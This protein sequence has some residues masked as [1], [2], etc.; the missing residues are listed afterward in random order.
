MATNISDA[1]LFTEVVRE[2]QSRTSSTDRRR[3]E[4]HAY[5]TV[6]LA[7]PDSDEDAFVVPEMFTNVACHDIST[8]GI[9]IVLP[10]P[11]GFRRAVVVLGEPPLIIYMIVEVLRS[12][13][14]PLSPNQFLVGCRFVH[15]ISGDGLAWRAAE[16]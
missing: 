11:P 6:R 1:A 4:R 9:S 15:R 5:P 7:I 10:C 13:R 12:E 16:D 14:H 8:N 2:L 3:S